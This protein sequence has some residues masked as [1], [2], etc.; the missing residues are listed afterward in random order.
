MRLHCHASHKDH[1]IPANEVNLLREEVDLGF[2]TLPKA[3]YF[4]VPEAVDFTSADLTALDNKALRG[5]VIGSY[6]FL[7]A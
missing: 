2:I 7:S 3:L 5:L 1:T 4:K 6:V